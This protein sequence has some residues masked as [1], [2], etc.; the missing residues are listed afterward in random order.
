MQK[1]KRGVTDNWFSCYF[2]NMKKKNCDTECQKIFKTWN[3]KNA[4]TFCTFR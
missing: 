1:Y 4:V 2:D 3:L